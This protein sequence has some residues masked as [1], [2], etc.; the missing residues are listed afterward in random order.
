MTFE[1]LITGKKSQDQAE[2]LA[3]ILLEASIPGVRVTRTN[4][5]DDIDLRFWKSLN[6]N[7]G[8]GEVSLDADESY[9]KFKGRYSKNQVVIVDSRLSLTW[10][11]VLTNNFKEFR[12]RNLLVELVLEMIEHQL[13][14]SEWAIGQWGRDFRIRLDR[15]GI[16]TIRAA[17]I[18]NSPGQIFLFSPIE[19]GIIE[20]SSDD[21]D[22]WVCS[23]LQSEQFVRKAN[24]LLGDSNMSKHL[25]IVMGSR[26]PWQLTSSL[27]F[28][29]SELSPFPKRR[30]PLH[31]DIE[32][33]WIL[34]S[35]GLD[36]F[37]WNRPTNSW[38]IYR[39]HR[40]PSQR[41]S[42]EPIYV[43]DCKI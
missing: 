25:V 28:R 29:N 19:A 27:F 40:I 36:W 18:L 23:K 1:E 38:S 22:E 7:V 16:S 39:A 14:D 24:Q 12:N 4:D 11:F 35:T 21:F 41:N 8:I 6:L 33:L 5:Q 31:P 17:D 42:V 13:I 2:E 15:L 32:G 26:T 20:F 34:A 30:P 3:A 9:E 43:L 10:S 37:Y